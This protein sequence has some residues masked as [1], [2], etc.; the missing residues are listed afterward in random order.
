MKKVYLTKPVRALNTMNRTSLLV[1]SSILALGLVQFTLFNNS[2]RLNAW[3]IWIG[4][5]LIMDF[6][7]FRSFTRYYITF[8]QDYIGL[9]LPGMKQLQLLPIKDVVHVQVELHAIQVDVNGGDQFIVKLEGCEDGD[10]EIIKSQFE[11][12]RKEN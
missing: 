5:G 4:I 2:L 1:G 6:F 8:S 11:I 7:F 9:Y 12:F 10:S 3:P